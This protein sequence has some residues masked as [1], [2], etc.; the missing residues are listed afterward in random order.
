VATGTAENHQVFSLLRAASESNP[1]QR[2]AGVHSG[3]NTVCQTELGETS[4]YEPRDRVGRFSIA[5]TSS[6]RST[7]PRDPW[8]APRS[9]FKIK[10]LRRAKPTH[11]IRGRPQIAFATARMP[12]P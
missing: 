12:V 7:K 5:Y 10:G 11:W 1:T 8:A 9:S 4:V 6:D 3:A 2:N